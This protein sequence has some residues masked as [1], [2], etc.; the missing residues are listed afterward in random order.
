MEQWCKI[1]ILWANVRLQVY[2]L[3]YEFW[4]YTIVCTDM[5]C[6]DACAYEMSCTP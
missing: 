3:V 6:T 2:L 1:V 4:L 5:F